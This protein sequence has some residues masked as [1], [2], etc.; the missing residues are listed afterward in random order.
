MISC[1]I[2][3]MVMFM[4]GNQDSPDMRTLSLVQF[5]GIFVS[6]ALALGCVAS[7]SRPSGLRDGLTQIWAHCPGWLAFSLGMLNLLA[8]AGEWAFSLAGAGFADT[9]VRDHV[10]LLCLSAASIA[11][12]SLF[13]TAH[14]RSGKPPFSKNRW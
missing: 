11:F 10:G 2:S 14:A 1:L 4:G 3:I 8:L 9:P 5:T 13:A 12:V 7:A 6:A